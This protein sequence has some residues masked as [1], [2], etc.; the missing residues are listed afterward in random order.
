MK[1]TTQEYGQ[2]LING[3]KN[4]T[5][6]YFSE[7]VEGL[8]HDSVSR[9]LNG[10]KLKSKVI[11]ERVKEDILYSEQGY[12][13]FED[14]VHDKSSSKKIEV[15]RWQYSATSHATVMGI[16]IVN[17]LYY[18]PDLNRY[19]LINARIYQ[20]DQDGKKK[21][22]HLQEMMEIAIKR[23]VVFRTVLM[24]TWYAIT[25]IMQ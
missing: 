4:Y 3:V 9:Y 20:P 15:A 14:S 10:S 1:V 25:S 19:W 23:G 8:K 11:W 2:F 21:Y 18:N 22:Q 13:L 6:T 5:A 24:D 7:I 17:C 12:L 16:G